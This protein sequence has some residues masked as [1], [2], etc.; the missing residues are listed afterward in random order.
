MS[1]VSFLSEDYRLSD[2]V[3]LE[4]G[5]ASYNLFSIYAGFYVNCDTCFLFK[6]I[7]Y[8]RVHIYF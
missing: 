8:I 7:L 2:H 6:L 4:L 5:Q 3:A 1:D